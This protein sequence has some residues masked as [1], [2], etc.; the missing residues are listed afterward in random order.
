MSFFGHFLMSFWDHF[1][2]ALAPFLESFLALLGPFWAFRDHFEV[3]FRSFSALFWLVLKHFLWHF[4]H[5]GHFWDHFGG[6]FG[7][8]SGLFYAVLVSFGI[9]LWSL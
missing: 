8:I 7:V 1:G 2:V 5:F 4:G 9:I 6:H 3:I